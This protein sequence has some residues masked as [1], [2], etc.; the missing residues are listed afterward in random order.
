MK[1]F[2]WLFL[3]GMGVIVVGGVL[4]IL[5]A[6][7]PKWSGKDDLKIAVVGS[8][9]LALATV[10]PERKMI[11]VLKVKG[12]V[13]V[14]VPF[15]YGLYMANRV[16]KFLESEKK[17]DKMAYVFFYNFG[18]W[19][20]KI[21]YLDNMDEWQSI[22]VFA[23]NMGVGNYLKLRAIQKNMLYNEEI[24]SDQP[25][26]NPILAESLTRDFA[27]NRLVG[28]EYRLTVRNSSGSVGLATWLAS[29]I[30]SAGVMVVGLETGEN[31]EGNCTITYGKQLSESRTLGFLKQVFSCELKEDESFEETE[32]EMNVG[33]SFASMIK[34]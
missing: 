31:E 14:W 34:Y 32:I 6:K 7:V 8:N 9:G 28:E 12:D 22:R 20:D 25:E 5:S 23:G 11:N 17:L 1:K 15:G 18:Y 13:R 10:S 29:R 27:D 33:K 3:I 16:E 24:L 4:N 21:I 19:P 26:N 30:E 2:K